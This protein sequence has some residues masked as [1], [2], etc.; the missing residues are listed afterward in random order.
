MV[1]VHELTQIVC[2]TISV[3]WYYV[4]SC[5]FRDSFRVKLPVSYTK[6]LFIVYQKQVNMNL[7]M[8]YFICS[9]YHGNLEIKCQLSCSKRLN[10][11]RI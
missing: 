5:T 7:V 3:K 1:N 8:F 9:M 10:L 6:S 4:A 2:G 11:Y